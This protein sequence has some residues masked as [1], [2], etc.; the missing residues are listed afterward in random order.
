MSLLVVVRNNER[1]EALLRWAVGFADGNVDQLYVVDCREGLEHESEFSWVN[2]THSL[3]DSVPYANCLRELD[4]KEDLEVSFSAIRPSDAYAT[5]M[6]EQLSLGSSLLLLDRNIKQDS[7]VEVS[8]ITRLLEDVN[9]AVMVIRLG[10][11]DGLNHKVLV[12][13]GGGPHSRH[14]LRMIHTSRD[15]V[16]TAFFVEPEVDEVSLDVGYRR[17]GK[18]LAQAGLKF[19]EIEKKVIM[20]EHVPSAI[21]NEVKAGDYGMLLLGATD[22]T[23]LRRKLFGTLADKFLQGEDGTAVG[24]I[25]ASRPI[26]HK[27]RDAVERF[28]SLRVPQLTRDERIALFSDIEDKSRWSFDFA[29]LMILATS[30]ASLG[31]LADSGAVVIGAMLVAPLMMPLLGGGLSLVQGNWPLWKRCQNAVLLGFLSALTIGV[32]CG[33]FARLFNFHL[34]SELLSRGNPTSLD[35]GVAF[36]SGLAAAYCFARPKISGALAG[37]AIAAALVPPIAT[38]GICIALGEMTVVR[39]AA[40]L[41]GTNVVAIV[42]GAALNFYA[43]GIRGRDGASGLWSRRLFIIVALLCVGLAVP[44]TSS[45]ITTVT[46]YN[47]EVISLNRSGKFHFN[48]VEVIDSGHHDK[49]R[50]IRVVIE[51][52]KSPTYSEVQKLKDVL[53][54]RYHEEIKLEVETVSVTSIED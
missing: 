10:G 1:A 37:V 3:L 41:F 2:T 44:L 24:V 8:Y 18:M 47:N 17:L 11:T 29:M 15:I 32:I 43:T 39:G 4:D 16:P 28:L 19:D 52:S 23:S 12:P 38:T 25:R 35:L 6:R 7:P 22:G 34:T 48:V 9:C 54:S 27:M 30:I 33:G 46:N 50:K 5:V 20:S 49:K 21:A 51:S 13:C 40:L 42:F 31:L 53:Q 45:L 26:G 36:V 14:A